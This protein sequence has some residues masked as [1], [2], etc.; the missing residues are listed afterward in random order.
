MITNMIQSHSLCMYNM[1]QFQV[2]KKLFH[3]IF[4]EMKKLHFP[5]FAITLTIGEGLKFK[6][7][8]NGKEQAKELKLK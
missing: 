7:H 3:T 1:M 8:G 6:I 2:P 5:E 4:K